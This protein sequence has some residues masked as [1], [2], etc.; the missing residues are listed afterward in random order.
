LPETFRVDRRT[1]RAEQP[2]KI[3][4]TQH[5]RVAENLGDTPPAPLTRRRERP[6]EIRIG[7]LWRCINDRGI[8]GR[9][10][11]PDFQRALRLDIDHQE[12]GPSGP[13][14]SLERYAK[15]LD[16]LSEPLAVARQRSDCLGRY[17]D[18]RSGDCIAV[19]HKGAPPTTRSAAIFAGP[20]FV[21]FALAIG[22][23]FSARPNV[24]RGWPFVKFVKFVN[25]DGTKKVCF[26]F[27]CR[28]LSASKPDSGTIGN[29][30]IG[31]DRYAWRL[32]GGNLG[33]RYGSSA[34]PIRTS[35]YHRSSSTI[36]LGKPSPAST[37]SKV[38]TNSA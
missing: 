1:R 12:K 23:A 22:M 11:F 28:S 4:R 8:R 35:F 37:A 30:A 27:E 2:R 13:L 16:K 33:R 18:R 26:G 9:V 31:A 34:K 15:G 14:H 36:T 10:D 17:R 5:V 25:S 7:D 38:A 24:G 21:D 3:I 6:I 29:S 19:E 32:V 20:R